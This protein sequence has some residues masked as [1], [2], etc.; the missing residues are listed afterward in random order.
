MF[1][2]STV[3]NRLKRHGRFYEECGNYI[4]VLT[5]FRNRVADLSM[6]SQIMPSL[7][8]GH[9]IL[10]AQETNQSIYNQIFLFIYLSMLD[11]DMAH[12]EKTVTDK[13]DDCDE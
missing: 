12:Y 10:C 9:S 7:S 11:E 5:I 1:E 4:T 13:V 8:V 6:P 2:D 3:A